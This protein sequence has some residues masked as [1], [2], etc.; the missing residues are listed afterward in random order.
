LTAAVGMFV[1]IAGVLLLHLVVY[2]VATTARVRFDQDRPVIES[3]L[4]GRP[5]W[6]HVG[7]LL[8]TGV[9]L[10]LVVFAFMKARDSVLVMLLDA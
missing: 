2:L 8:Q 7:W 4:K 6:L 10:A 3:R 5:L 9:L 1:S